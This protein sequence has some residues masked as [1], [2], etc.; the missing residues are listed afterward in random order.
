MPLSIHIDSLIHTG[1]WRT[2]VRTKPLADTVLHRSLPPPEALSYR[3]ETPPPLTKTDYRRHLS[4]SSGLLYSY[5]DK[6]KFFYDI[7]VRFLCLVR[8]FL[9][10]LSCE[11]NDLGGKV[12]GKIFLFS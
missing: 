4:K 11:R 8:L 6:G 1:E 9:I 5:L 2:L 3:P 12:T 10:L 7:C